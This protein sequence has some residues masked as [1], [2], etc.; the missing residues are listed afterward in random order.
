MKKKK[1]LVPKEAIQR[2][3]VDHAN[4]RMSLK[5]SN[6]HTVVNPTDYYDFDEPD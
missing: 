3:R 2:R 1:H 4:L 6:L 5:D